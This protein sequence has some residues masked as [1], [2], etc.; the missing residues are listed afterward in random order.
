MK[1]DREMELDMPIDRDVQTDAAILTSVPAGDDPAPTAESEAEAVE[2]RPRR[3]LLSVRLFVFVLLPA[4]ALLLALGNGYLKWRADSAGR[5]E[6]AAAQSVSAATE[7]VIALLSYQPG[8]VD[9]ELRAAADRLTGTFRDEYLTL[10]N[11][12]VIPGSKEKG[13]SAT[14]TVPAA[15]SISVTEN[16]AQVLVFV[17]QATSFGEGAPSHSVSSVKLTLDKEND[18][19]L[20]SQFEPV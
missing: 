1:I 20:V 14:V 13:I 8:S 4:I 19:W 7:T 12:V 2:V 18:R 9:T 11:D 10:I 17:N 6:A 5:S 16:K 3:R 15:A